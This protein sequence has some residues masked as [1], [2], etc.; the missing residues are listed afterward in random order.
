MA[1]LSAG[2]FNHM[3]FFRKS[4]IR[5]YAPLEVLVVAS[6]TGIMGALLPALGT[7]K[8]KANRIKCANNLKNIAS[9]FMGVSMDNR[10]RM[11]WLMMER[12]RVAMGGSK[13]WAF[14]VELLFANPAVKSNLGSPKILVSPSD[15]AAMPANEKVDFASRN[16]KEIDRR[17]LSYAVHLGADEQTPQAILGITRNFDGDDAYSYKEKELRELVGS[18]RPKPGHGR[19]LRAKNL[20]HVHFIG[21]DESSNSRVMDGLTTGQGNLGMSDGS[22]RMMDDGGFR[23]AVMMHSQERGGHLPVTIEDVTRPRQ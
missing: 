2:P 8:A 22:V 23:R 1:N 21:A 12:D 20:Q 18:G 7:A 10:G 9:G 15:P 17:A 3:K 11:P 14:D 6:I 4:T 5:G 13:E 16:L 19:S